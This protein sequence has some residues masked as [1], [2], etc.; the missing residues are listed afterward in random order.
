MTFE[1]VNESTSHPAKA[2]RQK[3]SLPQSTVFGGQP[4]KYSNLY[5]SSSSFPSSSSS[6]SSSSSFPFFSS[7]LKPPAK[8]NYIAPQNKSITNITVEY[9]KMDEDLK[10]EGMYKPNFLIPNGSGPTEREQSVFNKLSDKDN[11]RMYL[12]YYIISFYF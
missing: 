5:N 1:D 9:Q 3:S 12:L 2:S 8:Q 6:S 11:A 7:S 10:Y 4:F